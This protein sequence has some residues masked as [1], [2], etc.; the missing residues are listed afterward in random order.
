MKKADA[1]AEDLRLV[2]ALDAE[3][4]PGM[5]PPEPVLQPFEDVVIVH[6]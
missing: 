4:L 2:F 5:N 3:P 1:L 6:R